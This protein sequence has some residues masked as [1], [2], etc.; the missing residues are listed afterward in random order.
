M[1]N[2]P[3]HYYIKVDCL[4]FIFGKYTVMNNKIIIKIPFLCQKGY[5]IKRNTFTIPVILFARMRDF[6]NEI[7]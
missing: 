7:L 2:C 6:S 1:L 3:T 4:V 5:S